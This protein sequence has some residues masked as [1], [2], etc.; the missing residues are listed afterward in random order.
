MYIWFGRVELEKATRSRKSSTLAPRVTRVPA[1]NPSKL[2]R[3]SA[4]VRPSTRATCTLWQFA[5]VASQ[6]R[7]LSR[8]WLEVSR[9]GGFRAPMPRVDVTSNV[10]WRQAT[11]FLGHRSSGWLYWLIRARGGRVASTW[12]LIARNLFE[13]SGLRGGCGSGFSEPWSVA[14]WAARL[15]LLRIWDSR[16]AV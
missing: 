3:V 16:V 5:T 12:G 2:C 14:D 11:C 10:R 15:Q 4:P 8:L 1:H 9:G 13:V 6:P 7:P